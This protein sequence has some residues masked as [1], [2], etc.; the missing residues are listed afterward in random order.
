METIRKEQDDVARMNLD[1]ELVT[2]CSLISRFV[3]AALIWHGS[4]LITSLTEV[5]RIQ[6]CLFDSDY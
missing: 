3:N 2:N 4:G 5:K 1:K 6:S